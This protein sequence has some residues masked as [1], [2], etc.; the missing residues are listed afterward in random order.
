[1]TKN[2]NN[3]EKP[4]KKTKT[5]GFWMSVSSAV[6]LVIVQ[7]LSIFG[8]NIQSQAISEII[9]GILGALVVAGILIG[10]IKSEESDENEQN[11]KNEEDEK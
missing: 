5:Y 4:V 6:L 2:Q 7:I 8:I 10:P 3:E 11:E 1:M 9:S